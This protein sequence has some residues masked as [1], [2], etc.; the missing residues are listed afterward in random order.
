MKLSRKI[1]AAMLTICFLP[2]LAGCSIFRPPDQILHVDCEQGEVQLKVNGQPYTCPAEV[3]VRRNR[4][5][6]VLASKKGFPTQQRTIP[7]QISTT[8]ILDLAGGIIILVPAIGLAF[9][10]AFD[11]DTTELYIDLRQPPMNTAKK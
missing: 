1:V 2:P 10:G 11:L 9:P 7:F 6:N 4:A 5:V 3:P 8:G